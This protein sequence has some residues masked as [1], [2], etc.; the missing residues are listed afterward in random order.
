MKQ[1]R[2]LAAIALSTVLLVGACGGTSNHNNGAAPAATTPSTAAPATD[3]PTTT[4]A[5]KAAPDPCTLATQADA[6]AVAQTPV[7]AGV[8]SG[9][10]PDVMCQFLAPPT[11]PTA[12][13]E[14]FVGDGAKKQLDIDRDTLQHQFTTLTGIGDEAYLETGNVFVRKGTVWVSVNAVVLDAPA[15]QVQSAL[16]TLAAKIAAEL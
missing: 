4:A 11:G 1:A 5:P 8:R 16:Q 13:I 12:Q 14:V 10:P 15:A 7:A 2:A 3:A 6:Q 9:T